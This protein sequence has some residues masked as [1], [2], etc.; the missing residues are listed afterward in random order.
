MT[1][2]ITVER[3]IEANNRNFDLKEIIK[4]GE[5]G[6]IRGRAK[7]ATVRIDRLIMN[8]FIRGLRRGAG[9]QVDID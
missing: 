8:R 5:D 6:V 2:E 3:L 1:K 9:K 4:N 7:R